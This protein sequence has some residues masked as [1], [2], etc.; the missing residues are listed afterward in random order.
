MAMR[1]PIERETMQLEQVHIVVSN[2]LP[3]LAYALL[4]PARS[5]TSDGHRGSSSVLIA[6]SGSSD[7]LPFN[8]KC[9]SNSTSPT[10]CT[11]PSRVSLRPTACGC[12]SHRETKRRE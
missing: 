5:S 4:R 8:G 3:S 6:I 10:A 2:N 9:S 7:L 11:R 1:F 12:A